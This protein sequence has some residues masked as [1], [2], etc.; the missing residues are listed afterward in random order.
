MDR[1]RSQAIA[2]DLSNG[3]HA[4]LRRPVTGPTAIV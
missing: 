2:I 1:G 4:W 3:H